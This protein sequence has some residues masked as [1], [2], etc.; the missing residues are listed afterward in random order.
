MLGWMPVTLEIKNYRCFSREHPVTLEL[1]L[2]FTA[3]VGLNNSGKATLLRFFYEMRSFFAQTF[4]ESAILALS[5][6]SE[7]VVAYITDTVAIRRILDHL[8]LSPPERS[9]LLT[10]ERSSVCRW[11]NRVERSGPAQPDTQF[12]LDPSRRK[13]DS[14]SIHGGQGRFAASMGPNRPGRVHAGTLAW[15]VEGLGGSEASHR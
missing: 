2:G 11:T 9:H 12:N 8:G 14:V 13:G 6:G 7:K 5:R 1:R 4:D 3:L 15:L 10:S